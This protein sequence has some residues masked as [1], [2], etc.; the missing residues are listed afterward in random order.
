MSGEDRL[1]LLA[2][3]KDLTGIDFVQ[4]VDPSDQ[5]VLR[6][7]FVID[8]PDLTLPFLNPPDLTV[9]IVPEMARPGEQVQITSLAWFKG[10]ATHNRTVLEITVQAP[11]DFRHHRLTIA[12]P[13][14]RIDRFFNGVLFSFK[15]G[16]PSVFDCRQNPDCPPLDPVDFPV[17]YL[18]R[19]F[20]SLTNAL[21]DFSAQRYPLWK[22]RI[23]ADPGVMVAEILAAL[24]D[25]FA[26]TQDRAAREAYI[27]TAYERRSL[28]RLSTLID[29][30]IDDGQSAAT[31]LQITVDPAA[32][33]GLIKPGTGASATPEGEEP[34]PFE[35]G[36]GLGR[37]AD[38]Q[39]FFVHA[40]WNAL[41]VYAPD[42]GE[43]CLA[44]GATDLYVV[45][46][47][48]QAGD[49][50][51]AKPDD[52]AACDAWI[53]KQIL[54][55]SDPSDPSKPL[56][57]QIVTL[58]KVEHL[59]DPLQG[60]QAITHLVWQEPLTFSLCLKDPDTGAPATVFANIVAATAGETCQ[61][62]FA[63]GNT[64][65]LPL[66][67]QLQIP[68]AVEREGPQPPF[69]RERADDD[70]VAALIEEADAELLANR[71]VIKLLPLTKQTLD[72]RSWPKGQSLA[73][74]ESD[75]LGFI[76]G[77]PEILVVQTDPSGS[78]PDINWEWRPT[79]LRSLPGH[80]HF[81]L[82]E[83]I[84][85]DVVRYPTPTDEFR[86]VDRASANGFTVRFGD[87][88]FGRDPPDGTVFDV[89][90][91][92]HLGTHAN[93]TAGAIT[94]LS[95]ALA[96]IATAVTN[97]LAVTSAR[98]P[99]AADVIRRLAPD[100]YKADLLFAVRDEDY[101]SIL[102]REPFVQAAGAKAR[103]TGSW[104]TE[105]VAID[106][107]GSYG[108][109]PA[110]RGIC[111]AVIDEV[112]Q[113]GRPAFVI[114]PDYL[115]VDLRIRICV[116]PGFY[117]GQVIAEVYRALAGPSQPWESA[118]YFNPDR[119]TFGTRLE[120]AAIEAA[121]QS[122]PGVLGVEEIELRIRGLFDW[123][124]FAAFGFDPG[125]DRIIQLENDPDHPEAGSLFVTDQEFA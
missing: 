9:T 75:G 115:P 13:N 76:D 45:G 57:R 109:D 112:R 47:H 95:P 77:Q 22:E 48:P 59:T 43:T 26:Y 61:A 56:L 116:M 84:Y 62:K 18:A 72:G 5:H 107:R 122:V 25:E 49:F 80:D 6:V 83:G 105:F 34:I 14:G 79:L 101:R 82:D 40:N 85:R 68:I 99:M 88:V 93:V 106:E 123:R 81:T 89:T 15:Q 78:S 27:D 30:P 4:V 10:A 118:P 19:D 32:I 24:G 21:L 52:Q 92:T 102:E 44:Q 98:D 12:D 35:T 100:A 39:P 69:T 31:L 16:C 71:P 38:E 74:T 113:A 73:D 11:G 41:P 97:P 46:S 86:Q 53:N 104:L 117:A 3:Q 110:S 124:D 8:P 63:I 33:S 17:D 42:P 1:T 37:R 60:N 91:R 54:I 55:A 90:Y 121:V 2:G 64:N 125:I 65:T 114:D 87:G 58:T 36:G 20:V 67:L 96:A 7:F 28:R 94:T 23:P 51:P 120:R 70:P 111:E 29:Y 66:A 119:F 103:W 108:L 50:S